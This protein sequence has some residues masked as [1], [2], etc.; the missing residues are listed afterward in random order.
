MLT[1]LEEVRS[2]ILATCSPL[3]TVALPLGEAVGCVAAAPV[4]ARF[5]VPPFANTA[6]DGYALRSADTDPAPARLEV[7]GVLAAGAAP[8]RAVG[9]GQALRIMTGAPI[10]PGADAVVMVERTRASDDGREVLIEVVATPGQSVREA[11]SDLRAGQEVVAP[12]TPL[13]A[14]HVGVL[15]SLGEGWVQVHRRPV[16]GVLTTGDELVDGPG[17][18]RPGQIHDSN[19]PLLL[20]L[21]GQAGC[22]PVDLG[23]APDDPDAIASALEQAIERCDVVLVTGGVSVGDFDFVGT[24]LARLGTAW[25]W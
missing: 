6:M 1:P 7:I 14:G 11:G 2:T 16:V 17:P 18:L 5:D 19:R 23:R 22:R 25:A 3:P 21:A 10:P 20:A 8:D 12:G 13:S 15:A 24:V 9:P 4:V